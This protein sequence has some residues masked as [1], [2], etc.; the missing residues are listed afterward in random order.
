M[1]KMVAEFIIIK[2]N[3][4]TYQPN[5]YSKQILLILLYIEGILLKMDKPVKK[6]NNLKNLF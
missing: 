1:V 2:A 5:D 6:S 4:E 3:D